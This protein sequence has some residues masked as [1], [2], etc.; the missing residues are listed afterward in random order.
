MRILIHSV[1]YPPKVSGVA[2]FA[3]SLATRAVA[4]GHE[5]LVL[6]SGPTLTTHVERSHQ[7]PK[8]LRVIDLASI[9]NPYHSQ[10]TVPLVSRKTI[11]RILDEFRP[12]VVH[13]QDPT[14]S[15]LSVAAAA[16]LRGIPV[17]ATHHFSMELVQAYQPAWLWPLV[18]GLLQWWL[19][20]YY[21][22]CQ[23]ITAPSETTAA[24]VRKLGVT[25]PVMVL[26]NGVEID[27]FTQPV[28][29]ASIRQRFKLPDDEPVLLFVGR[30]DPDKSVDVLIRAVAIARATRPVYLVL[31]GDGDSANDLRQLAHRLGV[32]GSVSLTGRIPHDDPLLAG[33][34]ML[35]DLFVIA[36]TIETQGIV[37][38]EA[39]AAGLPVVAANANALPEL[40][41]SG[42]TG[43]LV[44]PGDA[45]AFA[46]AMI[47]LIDDPKLRASLSE[48]AR[49]SVQPHELNHC[50][51]QFIA[52]YRRLLPRI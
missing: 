27:R 29:R 12:D 52:E 13:G 49:V 28:D 5:V 3:H 10:L 44:E 23:L 17:L 6:T 46:T 9:R 21:D 42:E 14:P 7:P 30:L 31:V 2:V 33:L 16:R 26:S 25:A 41:V 19:R 8:G 39:M 20:R 51:D 45:A 43:E 22:H 34:F 35:A 32:A 24:D 47:A 40:V 18:R 36:S 50:L 4:S 15:G 48:R 38:I 11:D 1:S 37:V